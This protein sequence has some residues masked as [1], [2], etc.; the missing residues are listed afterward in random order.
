MPIRFSGQ[1]IAYIAQRDSAGDPLAFSDLNDVSELVLDPNTE[2]QTAR[3]HRSGRRLE[4][5]RLITSQAVSVRIV[6]E[7]WDAAPNLERALHGSANAV[8][9]ASV[10]DEVI[11]KAGATAPAIGSFIRLANPEVSALTLADST[12]T[13]VSLVLGTDYEITSANHGTLKVLSDWSGFTLPILADYTYGDRDDVPLFNA[14]PP[15]FWLKFDGL[16]TAE[17]DAPVLVELYRCQFDPADELALIADDFGRMTLNG[18]VLVDT[19]KPAGGALGQF[20][21]VIHV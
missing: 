14:T 4:A 10:T 5:K 16:N 20:G 9:G 2:T 15:D 6:M 3:E 12:G 19:T 21:R 7:E 11:V 8:T 17:A 13:P 18:S 1:G